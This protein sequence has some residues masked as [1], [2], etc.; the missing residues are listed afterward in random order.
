MDEQLENFWCLTVNGRVFRISILEGKRLITTLELNKDNKDSSF[1]PAMFGLK[2]IYGS[3]LFIDLKSNITLEES[4]PDLREAEAK[5][6]HE[7]RTEFPQY[8]D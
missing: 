3:D 1:W 2:D 4:T 5:H 7:L 6:M 8:N